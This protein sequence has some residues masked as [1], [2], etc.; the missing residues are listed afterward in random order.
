MPLILA[1]VRQRQRQRGRR[2]AGEAGEAAMV[3]SVS[4]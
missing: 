4:I 1:L 2:E 3:V